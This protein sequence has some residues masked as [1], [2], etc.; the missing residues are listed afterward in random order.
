MSTE[1]IQWSSI[2]LRWLASSGTAVHNIGISEP[3]GGTA[4]VPRRSINMVMW[5]W[6]CAAAREKALECHDRSDHNLANMISVRPGLDQR[7]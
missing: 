6:S 1:G 4:P 3:E 5:N 7:R 2:G